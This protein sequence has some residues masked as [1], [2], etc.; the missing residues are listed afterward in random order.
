MSDQSS[1]TEPHA[2]AFCITELEPG[3]AER[4]L[5]ELV[6]RL[7]PRRFLPSVYSIAAAPAVDRSQLTSRLAEAGISTNFLGCS[8]PGQY[9]QAIRGMA[10]AF[11]ENRPALLQTFLFH[12]NV[13]GATAARRCGAIPVVAGIR[14]ADRRSR[15]RLIFEKHMTR[16]VLRHVCVSDEV[17]RFSQRVGRLPA[18]K[19][20]VIPNGIDVARFDNATAVSVESLGLSANRRLLVYVGRIDRQKRV[21]RIIDVFH[22]AQGQLPD[23]D[24]LVVGD[25]PMSDAVKQRAESYG[26]DDRVRLVGWRQDVPSILRTADLLLLTS[27]WEGMPNVVMEA[28]S[29]SKPVVTLDTEGAVQLLGEASFEQIV[30]RADFQEESELVARLARQVVEIASQPG[31]AARLGEANRRRVEVEFAIERT[32]QAYEALYESLLG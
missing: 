28:M 15:L 4:N 31:L 24:L 30:R 13:I 25:G 1:P 14:V 29:A 12:A 22:A 6:T 19:L 9:R 10:E 3:G 18:R 8:E 7:D 20:V 21:D 2:I 27:D 16:N 17:A 32:V 26:L 5:V 23:H 11:R